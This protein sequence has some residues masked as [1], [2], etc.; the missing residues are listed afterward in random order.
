MTAAAIPG[1]RPGL[2]LSFLLAAAAVMLTGGIWLARREVEHR[3]P[4]DRALLRE[5]AATLQA[6]LSQ[7]DYVYLGHLQRL[8]GLLGT[9]QSPAPAGTRRAAADVEGIAAF[10]LLPRKGPRTVHE[11]LNGPS[12][13]PPE[14]EL[15]ASGK[16]PVSPFAMA[17]PL[18]PIFG[19][20]EKA[21]LPQATESWIGRPT[22]P[23]LA[24]WHRADDAQVAVFV[25]RGQDI[26]AA[27]D[28][29]L[30]AMLPAVWAPVRA[31]GG[32][33]RVEG[34]GARLLAGFAGN[35]GV[36]PDFVIP[37][38]SR[39]GNWQIVS[40]DRW[41]TVTA[42]H[43]PTL[44]LAGTLAVGLALLG[45][46]VSSAQ[47]RALREVTA[48]V[49]FVNRVSHELGAPLT[50]LRLYM[51]LARDSLPPEAAES[52]RR[53]SVAQEENERLI[54][55]VQNV[56]TFARSERQKL[57]LHP[58]PCHPAEILTAVLD[59]F[60]PALAR[61]GITVEASLDG[62]P[63]ATLDHDAFAQIT[64]N[65]V[66]NVEKYAASGGW[67]LAAL[68][69]EGDALVLRISDRGPGIPAC[70]S[71]RVFLPFERLDSRLTEGVT[72]T[73]LGLAITRDLATRMHGT[74]TLTPPAEGTG[75]VFT[76]RLPLHGLAVSSPAPQASM[77]QPQPA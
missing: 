21:P 8:A 10:A 18:E 25:V 23:W 40:Y 75:C 46:L 24:W 1:P 37:L 16:R 49:S 56:L 22:D 54:R 36:A 50:N 72:G 27:I 44:I 59:Q 76:V 35:R 7:L 58:A 5:S 17:I 42:W 32:L 45:W 3:I 61:R 52:A 67:M 65:L 57:E 62:A 63:G 69:A 71:A 4:A 47:R 33:D 74:I 77:F 31:A 13:I 2:T 51:E 26:R 70:E 14:P 15:T 11:R 55:L 6:E 39:M 12:S 38:A 68:E 48:R 28:R 9:G 29:H 41:E 64:A 20:D 53:L 66:S 43:Q 19:K 30:T 73:G 60:S 34:P